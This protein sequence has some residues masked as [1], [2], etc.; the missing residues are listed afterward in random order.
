MLSSS[1]VVIVGAGHAGVQ[2]AASL[3][4]QGFQDEIV[5]LSDESELPYERPPLSKAFLKGETDIRGVPLR[6]S[7]RVRHG[8]RR[9]DQRGIPRFQRSVDGGC[10]APPLRRR[11]FGHIHRLAGLAD[12]SFGCDKA[13]PCSV[14]SYRLGQNQRRHG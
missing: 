5:L 14:E 10:S 11:H 1:S 8:V 12:R 4:E 7:P 3:R 2:A 6:T 9:D 13:G